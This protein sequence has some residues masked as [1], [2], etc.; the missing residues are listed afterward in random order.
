MEL[1]ALCGLVVQLSP[2]SEMVLTYYTKNHFLQ[3]DELYSCCL[4][5]L[6]YVFPKHGIRSTAR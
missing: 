6:L 4:H 2:F 5:L 1:L 3:V